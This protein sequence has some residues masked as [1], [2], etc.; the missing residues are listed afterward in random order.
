MGYDVGGVPVAVMEL[1]F[2][3]GEHPCRLLRTDQFRTI[4]GVEILQALQ[5]YVFDRVL[6]KPGNLC[7]LLERV[8]PKRQKVT[9]ILP[10]LHGYLVALRFERHRLHMGVP[11][12][13]APC[14][15]IFVQNREINISVLHCVSCNLW[16]IKPQV[17]R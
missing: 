1:E 5:V 17:L 15:V 10:E 9:G 8:G 2:V 3:Y 7:H 16:I 13:A 11:A 14:V 4:D 12:A 6:T